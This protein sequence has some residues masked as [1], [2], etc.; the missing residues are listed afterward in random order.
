[1]PIGILEFGLVA[2]GVSAGFSLGSRLR[3]RFAA[4]TE[5]PHQSGDGSIKKSATAGLSQQTAAAYSGNID[6]MTLTVMLVGEPSVGKTL[7]CERLA[8]SDGVGRETMPRTLVPQW[9]RATITLP[10]VGR[11][12]FQ[13]LDTPGVLPELSVPFYRQTQACI[14][15]FEVGSSLSFAKMKSLWYS[16]VRLHRFAGGAR[17]DPRTTIVLAHI[18]DERRER[19]VTR[20]EAAAWCQQQKPPLAYFE[21]HT[22]VNEKPYP[23]VLAHLA[24]T[25]LIERTNDSEVVQN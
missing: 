5:P 2:A 24:D 21:T 1:M 25:L 11:V 18:I 8:S 4:A 15:C 9:H 6:A 17:H 14:L 13:F 23:R 16:N 3:E 20:R 22:T 7:Y 12:C 19:Q 10:S